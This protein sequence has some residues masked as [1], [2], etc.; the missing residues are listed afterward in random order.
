MIGKFSGPGIRARAL[1]FLL[2]WSQGAITVD[3]IYPGK[4]EP[5]YRK[6]ILIAVMALPA[7]LA[8]A[9]PASKPLQEGGSYIEQRDRILADLRG[10]ETYSEIK[11]EDR[12]RVH[13]ALQR[14]DSKLATDGPVRLSEVDKL[15]VFN[16]QELVNSILAKAKDDSR[17][18]CR[19]ERPVGSNRPQNI[20][21]TVAQRREARESGGDMMRSLVPA[22]EKAVP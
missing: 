16:D 19:R 8:S 20:C 21:I 17:L 4:I 10:G 6:L 1:F 3:R 14:I 2:L 12:N 15:A 18:I 7:A 22:E 5:M 13:S 11:L 9:A